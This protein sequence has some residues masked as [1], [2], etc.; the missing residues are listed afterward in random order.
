LLAWG[1]KE[2]LR[3][4][5]LQ[6]GQP[7]R[8]VVEQLAKVYG[9]ARR[10]DLRA[11]LESAYDVEAV[12]KDFFRE[13]R[14]IFEQ[15]MSLITGLPDENR[16]RPFCQTLFNR[17]MF[18]YFVQR[19]GWLSF[20]GNTDYLHALWNDS[21]KQGENFYENRLKLLFFVS[22]S[23]PRSGKY[24][25]RSFAEKKTGRVPFLN[26]G[27]FSE[28]ELD[29]VPGV[30]VPNEAIEP[31]LDELFRRFNFTITES[32]PYDVQVAVDPEMLGK[33]FEELVTGR[34]KTGSYYT[35]RPIVSFMC[36]EALKGY[37]QTHVPDLIDEAVSHYVDHNDV[38]GVT[39]DQ[40]RSI[41]DAL[42]RIT[43]VDPACGSGAYLLG[44]MQELLECETALYN[45]QLLA[46]ARSLYDTKLRIIERNVYGVDID[47]FAMNIAMLRL[48]LSLIVEYEG[49]DDPPPLP[50]LDF[51]IACGD[52]L[53]G[54]NPEAEQRSLIQATMSD[55]LADVIA[56]IV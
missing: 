39:Q 34:H 1:E 45:P 13:Y 51:K 32:T 46:C 49:D 25:A 24:D 56:H 35:P 17:L 9:Q 47:P 5:V 44:M 18:I 8:T 21:I 33:V 55:T 54:P 31:L 30:S 28:D 37:L 12:T 38:S 50:N 19:K 7:H 36:R 10:G 43:V 15:S 4:M 52:S 53:T 42:E 40:A 16:R 2:I 48:W 23:H 3:R 11:A 41:L 20:D 22:L 26:G 29:K 27:L 6:R 14:R